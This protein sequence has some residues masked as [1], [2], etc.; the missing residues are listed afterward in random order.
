[1]IAIMLTPTRVTP[2]MDNEVFFSGELSGRKMIAIM[3]TLTRVTPR[4]EFFFWRVVRKKMIAIM[5]TPTRV[6]PRM[7][8]EVF[9]LAS[10]PEEK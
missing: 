1:M 6:T 3:L 9:F 7:D 2:R 5:L 10:C 8:N 4:M